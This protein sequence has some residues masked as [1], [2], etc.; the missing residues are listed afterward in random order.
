[1][2]SIQN[3]S[4]KNTKNFHPI[5][6]TIFVHENLHPIFTKKT[7]IGSP[8]G[9]D[10]WSRC[11]V[12]LDRLVILGHL[13]LCVF[14]SILL[15]MVFL[16]EQCLKHLETMFSFRQLLRSNKSIDIMHWNLDAERDLGLKR[17][18]DLV[19]VRTILR[20]ALDSLSWTCWVFLRTK[21]S[22]F[23]NMR[24]QWD[25]SFQRMFFCGELVIFGQMKDKE[26]LEMKE[27]RVF[28]QTWFQCKGMYIWLWQILLRLK[29]KR[30]SFH[31]PWNSL[32]TSCT[33]FREHKVNFGYPGTS[34]E[35]NSRVAL[36]QVFFFKGHHSKC[37]TWF[38]N[39]MWYTIFEQFWWA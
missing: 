33:Y 25:D 32:G 1:M 35:S 24:L 18:S 31:P 14:L 11:S 22:A 17:W 9:R 26:L 19:L 16:K 5:F 13:L 30:D 21:K 10:K 38:N 34:L 20:S 8:R 29:C 12:V 36:V 23:R 15:L 2:Q 27:M 3:E 6:T 39:L 7:S 28:L 4:Q 37:K